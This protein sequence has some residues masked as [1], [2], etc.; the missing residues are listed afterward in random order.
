MPQNDVVYYAGMSPELIGIL[1]VGATLLVGLGGLIL[2]ATVWIGGW[3]RDVD[4]RLARVEGRMDT[5]ENVL[6][7]VFTPR[8]PVAGD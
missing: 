4:Q 2:T 5:L 3:L 1:G 6:V 8:E 7:Q